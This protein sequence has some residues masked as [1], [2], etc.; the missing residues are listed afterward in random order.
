MDQPLY[1]IKSLSYRYPD[2]KSALKEIDLTIYKN[3]KIALVGQNGSGKTTFVKHLN[4]ILQ[5]KS[6]KFLYKGRPINDEL[7]KLRLEIG[8]VFQDADDHL[9]C[10]TLYE[11][12]AFGLVNKKFE[13]AEVKERVFQAL[14]LVGLDNLIYKSPNNLSYGQKKRAAFAAV[15][16]MEPDVLI[17]DE[18]TANLDPKQEK[19]FL[20][21]LSKYKGTLIC[22]THDLV[23][24]YGICERAVVLKNGMIH[25]DYSLKDLISQKS[26]LRE[27]GLDFSF[28][29]S[30]CHEDGKHFHGPYGHNHHPSDHV[31]EKK[32]P[33]ITSSD[34]DIFE[35]L[36]F[37]NYSYKYPD[38]SSAIKNI[39]IS[40][41]KGESL[42]FIGENGAGK[43]TLA[44]CII[45]INKGQGD[46]YFNGASVNEKY[47]KNLWKYCGLVFQNSEDQ[48]FCPSCFEEVAFGP[49]Q[50][51]LKKQEIEERVFEALSLVK[52]QGYEKRVPHH[53]SGG[54]KKRLS[55]ASILSMKPEVL[56]LDE[57]TASLDPENEE[58][59]IEI[60]K[61][62][63][64]TKILISHDLFFISMLCPRT[65]VMH[66]GN[67]I[68]DYKT[69]EF[70]NDEK[71][72]SING[73]DYTFKNQC[74]HEIIKSWEQ[75]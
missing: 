45:G 57:P 30:C 10:N 12:I 47:R 35:V 44:S 69:Y 36:R 28:R 46:Y 9:F 40:I 7:K 66:N 72:T 32:H 18:P 24:A 63:N 65:I 60:L 74:C 56:I 59:L 58:I 17:L 62:I 19:I 43:S 14:K 6:E 4:G 34:T 29:F 37:N 52:L 48:L 75:I 67:L 68:R 71:L 2:G 31:E 61:K 26:S 39:D 27:H 73:V 16:A 25:H 50:L 8:M 33:T 13:N 15:I 51:G 11:D 42:A 70:L 53:M 49:K 23:F 1:E 20:E 41:K 3:D 55:I 38:G 64:S 54:E 21:L 22:I 5:G